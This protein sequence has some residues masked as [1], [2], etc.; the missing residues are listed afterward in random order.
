MEVDQSEAAAAPEVSDPA[1]PAPIEVPDT[2]EPGVD[3]VLAGL[4]ALADT[5][6]AEHPAIYEAVQRGL[7]EQLSGAPPPRASNPEPPTGLG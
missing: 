7:A 5:P 6:L 4:W 2:G 1:A 3:E